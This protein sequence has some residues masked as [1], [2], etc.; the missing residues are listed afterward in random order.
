MAGPVE[1]FLDR[2]HRQIEDFAEERK[3]ERAFVEVE[4][5]DGSRYTVEGLDPQPG[6]GFV[7]IRP[8]K[9][10]EDHEPDEV[11]VQVGAIKRVEISVAGEERAAFGFTIPSA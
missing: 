4:L 3:L 6:F 9:S 10:E 2:L 5:F 7:T 1:A 11:V 8:H